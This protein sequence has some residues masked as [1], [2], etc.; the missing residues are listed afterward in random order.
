MNLTRMFS[1]RTVPQPTM[2]RENAFV[3][4]LAREDLEFASNIHIRDAPYCTT[5]QCNEHEIRL[6]DP[7]FLSRFH[8]R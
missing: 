2:A 1:D 7:K 8:P 4:Q 6:R 3:E 5:P